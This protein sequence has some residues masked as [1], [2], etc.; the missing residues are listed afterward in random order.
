M[1]ETLRATPLRPPY[2]VAFDA[3]AGWIEHTYYEFSHV[4]S[5]R[6]FCVEERRWDENDATGWLRDAHAKLHP[7]AP[8]PI[9]AYPHSE[10][11]SVQAFHA[12]SAA[13]GEPALWLAALSFDGGFRSL[14][15]TGET[16]ERTFQELL[17]D[18]SP[19]RADD[20]PQPVWEAR[21]VWVVQ[22]PSRRAPT[23]FSYSTSGAVAALS[24]EENSDFGGED[25]SP[26]LNEADTIREA[27]AAAFDIITS[28]PMRIG[29][30]EP[31][32]LGLSTH[33]FVAHAVWSAAQS[34][35]QPA[36]TGPYLHL[37]STGDLRLAPD[38]EAIWNHLLRTTRAGAVRHG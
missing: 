14:S 26:L 8:S 12:A 6:R 37:R 5:E 16:S 20:A 19:A 29:R 31:R 34:A 10:F 3:P 17:A 18:L 11:A 24:W 23:R 9:T 21:G 2:G 30:L 27:G 13:G 25:L 15:V 22:R 36:G 35:P 32:R 4:G 28:G 1:P 7:V 38:L 33:C